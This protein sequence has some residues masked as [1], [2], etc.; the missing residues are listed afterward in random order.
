MGQKR[1]RAQK[2]VC[3]LH[4]HTFDAVPGKYPRL[5]TGLYLDARNMP[6]PQFESKLL[7]IQRVPYTLLNLTERLEQTRTLLRTI[8]G[9]TED[10]GEA[11]SSI[12]ERASKRFQTSDA[13]EPWAYIDA[14]F[15]MPTSDMCKRSFPSPG[16]QW[17]VAKKVCVL[18][19]K[20][21][22]SFGLWTVSIGI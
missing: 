14:R 5:C 7:K 8:A 17:R 15:L 1:C 6:D 16:M 3:A 18:Q 19:T 22:S 9:E 13:T 2:Q 12:V 10:E 21:C 4:M 11:V 20:I